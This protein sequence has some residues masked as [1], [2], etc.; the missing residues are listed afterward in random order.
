M[1][2]TNIKKLENSLF[3]VTILDKETNQTITDTYD[4]FELQ[5]MLNIA[6]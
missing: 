4:E 3:E 1:E 5:L 2:I 6:M